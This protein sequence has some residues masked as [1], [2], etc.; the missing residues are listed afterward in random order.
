MATSMRSTDRRAYQGNK[1]GSSEMG[2]ALRVETGA[3]IPATPMA[4]TTTIAENHRDGSQ[5][6]P[7]RPGTACST[8]AYRASQPA[9]PRCG[10]RFAKVL[11]M[12]E[13]DWARH[14]YNSLCGSQGKPGEARGLE[15]QTNMSRG[16]CSTRNP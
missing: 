3:N 16:E 8:M 14:W 15:L 12:S 11:S 7:A 10:G 5:I 2:L 6:Q 13:P 1:A 4:M 9:L